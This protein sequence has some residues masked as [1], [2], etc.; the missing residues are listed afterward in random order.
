MK[1][2]LLILASVVIGAAGQIVL[3][4]GASKSAHEDLNILKLFLNWQV[5]LG[6]FLYGLSALVWIIVLRKSELSY[7]YPL[8]SLGYIIV[9]IASFFLFQESITLIRGFGLFFILIGIILIAKS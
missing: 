5:F 2:L 1:Q 7:A 8:V 9:F 3:K 6:L 4:I